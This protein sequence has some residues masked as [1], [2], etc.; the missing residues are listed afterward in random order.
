M[1]K[2]KQT[3]EDT[4]FLGNHDSDTLVT[5]YF[6]ELIIARY[7]RIIPIQWHTGIGMRLEVIG[8]YEPYKSV[9]TQIKGQTKPP[10]P[11]IAEGPPPLAI[12]T[13]DQIINCHKCG[14]TSIAVVLCMRWC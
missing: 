12:S 10:N 1:I 2:N 13:Q 6:E 7:L 3:N 4:V 9:T 5:Q 11:Y 8:C 14:H